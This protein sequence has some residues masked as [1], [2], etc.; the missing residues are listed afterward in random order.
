MIRKNSLLL[1]TL[2]IGMTAFGAPASAAVN[3]GHDPSRERPSPSAGV[4]LEKILEVTHNEE[5]SLPL[6]CR[7]YNVSI[8]FR[9]ELRALNR[10]E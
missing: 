1:L 5:R 6:E 2:V 10:C 3:A 9:R 7:G 8:K 4:P